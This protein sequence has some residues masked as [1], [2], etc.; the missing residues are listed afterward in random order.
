MGSPDNS[1]P[2]RPRAVPAEARWD[3]KDAG[4]EW[5]KGDVDGDGRRHGFYQCWTRDG[6]L[7]GECTYDHGN[8]D[9]T[10]RNFHPDGTIASEATWVAGTI[11]DSA[12][13]RSDQPSPEPF[14]Q[15]AENVWSVRYYT[16]D[17][18]TNYSIRY[19]LRDGTECGP[20]GQPLPRRPTGV[21]PDARWFPDMDRWVD[22]E[23]ARGT[24]LQVGHW[25]W[26]SREGTLRHEEKRDDRGEPTL[27]IQYRADG[28]QQKRTA[29]TD[30]GEERDYHFD[31]GSLST[32][33]RNDAA[34]R[35]IYKATWLRDGTLDDETER[36]YDGDALVRVRERGRGGVTTFEARREGTGVAC[37]LYGADGKT[38]AAAGMIENDKLAGS[39]KIF[40]ERGTLR[41]EVDLTPFAFA[42][43]VTGRDLTW[44]LGEAC[45]RVDEARL[46]LPAQ[47]EG[48][49]AEPWAQ[50][51][52]CYCEQVEAFPTLLRALA[53]PDPFVRA[54]ALGTIESEIEHQG[55]TYPAT[56]R[57]VPYLAR[58][59]SHPLVDRR[60][61]L[62]TLQAAGEVE[63]FAA[64]WPHVFAL[65]PRATPEERRQILVLAKFA[66]DAQHSL[67]ELAR[68]DR[69]PAVRA[70]AVDSL[71]TM[72]AADLALSCLGDR[73]PLVRASAAIA[74]ACA[75]G[76]AT[77]RDVV[78]ALREALTAWREL[79][80]RFAEL[81]FADGHL[82][83]YI[84]LAAGS[85]RSPDARSLAQALCT[86]IDE[87]DARSAIT[88]GQGLLA[89]ALGT[90]ERPFAKRCVEIL[91]ALASSRAFWVF[92]VNAHE[93]LAK[94]NLPR[95]QAELQQLVDE[96]QT[97]PDA[98]ALLY[99]R[100]HA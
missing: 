94:W 21:S 11:M 8:V 19:F 59:L 35:E 87:V 51:E 99:A 17:G 50:I 22:G 26:W 24:N 92:N 34:G 85:V 12:F 54:Y 44:R 2:P 63:S 83:A 79:A 84:A 7:H 16:R 46:P 82:L 64:A 4:F 96:L 71:A 1:A 74:I 52:G 42:Q 78:T 69:D 10:N 95:D 18:K 33:Y 53:S 31:D 90:G 100:I 57:V 80:D 65:F 76:P 30:H 27:V 93:I 41:R 14:A 37:V 61:L 66:P 32:R 5:V 39:W 58:L 28:T 20:D 62:A 98:E 38:L 88:Y 60:A 68:H 43:E 86:G 48:V 47:L 73:D 67:L 77:G 29:R 91:H 9:G 56:E 70:V 15:A 97:A 6:R 72:N 40:D 23:I 13:F 49:D 55:S 89:L 75:K 81:P 45:F 3:P 36:T 25:R